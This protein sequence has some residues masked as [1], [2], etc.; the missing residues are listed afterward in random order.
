MVAKRSRTKSMAITTTGDPP[1]QEEVASQEKPTV[2]HGQEEVTSQ[3]HGQEEE[4]T[5][6]ENG[7]EE[8]ASQEKNPMDGMGV[9]RRKIA[10]VHTSPLQ[11][12]GHHGAALLGEVVV[13]RRRSR[14]AHACQHTFLPIIL[15]EFCVSR[16]LLPNMIVSAVASPLL[17]GHL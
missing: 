11:E 12:A 6:Q 14:F 8:V 13:A 7:L 16:Y 9:G 2:D 1:H 3:D 4:V 17:F 10:H 5:S 15:R